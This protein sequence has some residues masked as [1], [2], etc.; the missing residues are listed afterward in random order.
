MMET[1]IGE[2]I[3]SVIIPRL[4]YKMFGVNVNIFARKQ[5]S[6]YVFTDGDWG[7]ASN[8]GNACGVERPVKRLIEELKRRRLDRTQV[9][10][11]FVQFGDKENG[12]LHLE[13]LDECG[14]ADDM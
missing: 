2:L 3:D 1:R 5:V 6:V 11:H 9:S 7:D 10:L 8:S 13:R 4:P 12:K 14:R